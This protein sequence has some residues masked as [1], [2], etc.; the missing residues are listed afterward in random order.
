MRVG[1]I[2]SATAARVLISISSDIAEAAFTIR[3]VI[4]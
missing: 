2:F 3:A 4:A 1:H